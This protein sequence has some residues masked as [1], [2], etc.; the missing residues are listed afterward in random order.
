MWTGHRDDK[1][2]KPLINMMGDIMVGI[3]S[4]FDQQITTFVVL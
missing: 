3:I 1:T 4:K 2:I